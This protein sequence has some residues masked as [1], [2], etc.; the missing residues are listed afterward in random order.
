MVCSFKLP[1]EN[2]MAH[3]R[4]SGRTLKERGKSYPRRDYSNYFF[5]YLLF[6]FKLVQ[7]SN[8]SI[9]N[10]TV[11]SNFLVTTTE[12]GHGFAFSLTSIWSLVDSPEECTKDCSI[13]L[14]CLTV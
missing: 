10:T 6:L 1:K 13:Y 8:T 12:S 11:D 2:P 3:V 5:N 9:A 7:T 14:H 4:V